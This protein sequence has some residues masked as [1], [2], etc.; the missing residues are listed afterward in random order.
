MPFPAAVIHLSPAPKGT[1]TRV[2]INHRVTAV[3]RC[4]GCGAPS[5]LLG[6]YVIDVHGGVQPSW[7]CP[8]AC[9]VDHYIALTGWRGW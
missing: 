1:W 3:I 2:Q 4:P 6:A 8:E 5:S 9:G 7:K